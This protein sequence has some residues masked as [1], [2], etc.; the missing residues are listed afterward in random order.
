MVSST[1]VDASCTY[2]LALALL[3]PDMADDSESEERR[4]WSR[5]G[6]CRRGAA[7]FYEMKH[8]HEDTQK[9]AQTNGC[10]LWGTSSR[11]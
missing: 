4:D 2:V 5:F 10:G 8:A 7:H 1:S 11:N 3:K 9:Y 6:T